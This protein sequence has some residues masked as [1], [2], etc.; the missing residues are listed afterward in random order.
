MA[1]YSTNPTEQV[2]GPGIM[3]AT[4]GGFLL[5]APRGRLFDV[6]TDRDYSF[7]RDKAEVLEMSAIDYS[8]EKLVVHVAHDRPGRRIR[9]YAADHGKRLLHVPLGSLSPVT[10][11]KIRVMHVL[12]G[13]DK[14]RIAESYVW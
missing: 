12:A 6:W 13:K 4:Y 5:T 1:Y 14:R 2:V 10:L 9:R 3:R 11:K 8:V 7:A